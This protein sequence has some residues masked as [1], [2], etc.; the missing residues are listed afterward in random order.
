MCWFGPSKDVVWRQLSQEI[1]AEFSDGGFSK[2]NKV[3]AHVGIWTIALDIYTE[4]TEETHVTYT[5]MRAPYVDPESFWFSIYR[6]GFFN[7]LGKLLG[8]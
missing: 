2:G 4:S 7:D 1:G 3:Q 8:M 5:R 6:K